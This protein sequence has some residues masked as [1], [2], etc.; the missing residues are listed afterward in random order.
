MEPAA[1]AEA[2]D[3]VVHVIQETEGL[4]LED[5]VEALG[6]LEDLDAKPE[7]KNSGI[8]AA[9]AKWPQARSLFER[10]SF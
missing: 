3:E 6:V 2:A 9:V 1:G 7:V 4:R 5:A 8:E 10:G